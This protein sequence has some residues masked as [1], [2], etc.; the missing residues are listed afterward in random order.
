MPSPAHRPCRM[1]DHP[2]RTQH[3]KIFQA[4]QNHDIRP[5]SL[6]RHA[7]RMHEHAVH[8]NTGFPVGQDTAQLHKQ[9]R[10]QRAFFH[11]LQN[12]RSRRI[13]A[14]QLRLETDNGLYRHYPALS[15][16][17]INGENRGHTTADDLHRPRTS[18]KK[19]RQHGR[20]DTLRA[21]M[22]APRLRTERLVAGMR[23]RHAEPSVH[24]DPAIQ[25]RHHT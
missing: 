24:R 2:F 18:I 1:T 15:A 5:F 3:E 17:T 23:H 7:D 19:R 22:D 20:T 14:R 16:G 25:T 11:P 12:R 8:G 13:P 21:G 10:H 4:L 9:R 6:V